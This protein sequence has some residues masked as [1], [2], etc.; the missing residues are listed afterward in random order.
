MDLI[1][2]LW[3]RLL[4]INSDISNILLYYYLKNPFKNHG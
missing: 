1:D 4:T 3:D 2:D